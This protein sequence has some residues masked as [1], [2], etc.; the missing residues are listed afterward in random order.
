VA[1]CLWFAAQRT[2]AHAQ[3]PAAPGR[4][5]APPGYVFTAD[6]PHDIV[7]HDTG[8]IGFQPF[9]DILAWD[10]FLALNWPVPSPIKERGVA[11]RQN[12]IGGFVTR[13]E[14]GTK[15]MPTGPTV[16]ET[17][18]DTDDIYLNP[19]VAPTSFDTPESIPAPCRIPAA[20]NPAAARRTLVQTAKVSDV[21][22]NFEQAFTLFPLIDQNGEKVWY[23]VKVN[24]VYYDYVVKN[25]F[26]DSRNQTGK[27]IAFPASSNITGNE[28]AVK[29]KA[30]W[31]IM[32]KPGSRQPDDPKR[33]YTTEAL[34]LDPTTGVCTQRT[35]GLVGLH[36]VVKTA[37]L[38]QWNWAT[39]E[40]VDN[41]PDVQS[42]PT[43]G[44]QYNFFSAKC[45]GCPLNAPPPKDHP[46]MP[47][48]VARLIPVSST[49]PNQVY[50]QALQSLRADN[51]WQYYELVDSQ[52]AGVGVPIGKP[53]QPD[54]LANTTL[55]TYLQG[56]VDDPKKPH[57]CINCHGTYAA[58]KDLDF[59][60]FKAYPHSKTL[61]SD[62]LAAH[63]KAVPAKK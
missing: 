43:P 29:V 33:F 35:V 45:A 27:T 51:V 50:Q 40:Q 52:W 46:N 1:A 3:A 7:T 26:Y 18:K 5:Y 48:Q 8:A 58:Q 13:G 62:I 63:G 15:T 36:I 17:F 25:K 32:G 2:T 12:V 49:A 30:A 38:P 22:S 41:D 60:L 11:D 44:K 34:V 37:Q 59:Q 57:G 47:T 53:S 14:G 31:K 55:E 24:R 16:W 19:P 6:V 23:E 10:S 28:A 9:V 42:G 54:Y 4:N 61:V 39:F 20:A 56:A 21:L